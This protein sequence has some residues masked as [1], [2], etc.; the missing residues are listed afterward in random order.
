METVHDNTS[1]LLEFLILKNLHVAYFT[2]IFWVKSTLLEEEVAHLECLS[3]DICTR[4]SFI[5]IAY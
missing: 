5:E 3:S 2:I 4:H 1:S